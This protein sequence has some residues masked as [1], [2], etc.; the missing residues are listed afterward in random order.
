[1]LQA[2]PFQ[3]SASVRPFPE[4][5]VEVPIAVHWLVVVHETLLR[6]AI[7]EPLGFDVLWTLQLVPSHVS[8]NVAS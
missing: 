1:M 5:S 8:F 3:F 6:V 4:L 2:L 7:R